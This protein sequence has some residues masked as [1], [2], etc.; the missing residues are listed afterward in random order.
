VKKLDKRLEKVIREVFPIEEENIDENWTSDDIPD[1]DSVGHLNLIM[2]IEK[3][4]DIKIEIEEMF[5]VEKL[6]DITR[7]L[8][9]K[10]VL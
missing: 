7:I 9:K 2:E 6:G 8:K 3:A 10:N 1:W 5:E 4:F